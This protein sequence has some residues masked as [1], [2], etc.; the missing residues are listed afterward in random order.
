M[1]MAGGPRELKMKVMLNETKS[2]AN[3]VAALPRAARRA[4]SLWLAVV[5]LVVSLAG[6]A[7]AQSSSD[8]G[9]VKS[10]TQSASRE[11]V[12]G[13][14]EGARLVTEFEVNGLKVLVKR[15]EGSQ[16]VVTGL[17]LRGGSRN[18]TAEN[19]GVEALMLDVATEASQ[20][21][22]RERF[23]RELSSMGTNIS[24]GVNYDYSALTMGSTRRHFD[25]SWE[26]FT[27]T[28]LHPSFTAED[29]QRVKG[30]LLVSLSDNEDTPDSF[31][32]ELQSRVAYA[33]HPYMNEPR[34]SVASVTRLTV[35]DVKRYHQQVMQTSR[36]LLVVVGDVD[37]Q[38]IRR[39]VEASF[40]RL[41]RGDYKPQPLPPL[42][43]SA[44]TL[45]VTQREI[46]TNYVQ[47]VFA[48]PPL[49]SADIY[50]MRIASAILQNR[51][52][53]EVRVRRNLSYAPDAFLSSQGANTGGIYVTAVDANQAV[54]VMLNEISRLQHEPISGDDLKGTAQSFLTRYYLGQE[55]NA[56]QAGELAQYELIGGGWRNSLVFLERLRAVTPGDVQRVANTYMRNLQFVVIGDP[57]Q[58][59]R[60]VFTQQAGE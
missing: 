41:P 23:R 29:F 9:V 46:P 32:Q 20:N 10:P 31:L 24:Y 4:R 52:Y 13:I 1:K 53:V 36:L 8:T 50:P 33:G 34:G 42:S 51:V 54:R 43:F 26:I 28:A 16:T 17:F 11:D 38:E 2:A 37:P 49:T 44:P 5:L 30:R 12:R 57:R 14:V 15:R 48:A 7:S 35:E 60:G 55:T 40:G 59:D 27:D 6:V 3:E 19:A 25:H 47:G 18:L 45:A 56:A 22:P 21:F 58:I 39:K